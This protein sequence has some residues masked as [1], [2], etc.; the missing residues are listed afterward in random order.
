MKKILAKIICAALALCIA[1]TTLVGCADTTWSGTVTLVNSGNVISNGGFIAE[2]ENLLYFINGVGT[3]TADNKMGAPVKGSLMVADKSDLTKVE[4]V[5]PKLMVATDYDAGVFVDG[6]YAYYGTPSVERDSSGGIANYEMT[7][8][9]TKLDGSGKTDQYFTLGSLSTEYRF[10]KANNKVLI[11]YFDTVESA[12]VCYDTVAKT[13]TTV[14]KT[15][16]KAEEI[17]LDSSSYRL[18]DGQNGLVAIFTA[19][20]YKGAYEEGKTRPTQSFNRIYG[21]KAGETQ[22]TVLIDGQGDADKEADDTTFA[23]TMTKENFVFYSKTSLTQ[24]TNTFGAI[25]EEGQL[26]NET[27]IVKTDYIADANKILIKDFETVYYLDETVL[28]KASLTADT[29]SSA[30]PVAL[31]EGISTMLKVRQEM[32]VQEGGQ[33]IEKDFLYYYNSSNQIAKKEL[34]DDLTDGAKEIRISPDSV[35]TT[36]YAPEFISITIG[37]ETKDY[38]FYCDNS[39]YGKS[40]IK[41]TDLGA[42]VKEEDTD[43]DDKKDL[44]YLD[45]DCSFEFG[46]VLTADKASIIS[47]KLDALSSDLPSG[48][49]TADADDKAETEFKAQVDKMIALYEGITD[50]AVKSAVKSSAVKALY[51]YKTAFEMAKEYAKLKGVEDV[52]K[53]EEGAFEDIYNEVKQTIETFKASENASAVD[54]LI[55]TNLKYYYQHAKELFEAK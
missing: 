9:R 28:L 12:I 34:V 36:W 21:V 5:V 39:A 46:A 3:S 47:A 33:E 14:V 32:I 41:Y 35:Y 54:A 25:I 27:K 15:D 1:L 31:S 7:F 29:V 37:S 45:T 19:T 44:F 11:Y 13:A 8:M 53:G 38:V 16:E 4:M 50:S 20:V 10:V 24:S 40:Y 26:K 2:T 30:L 55:N 23:I 18:F 17:S 51:N 48:G 52:N 43:D 22:P 6:G 49:L 42:T